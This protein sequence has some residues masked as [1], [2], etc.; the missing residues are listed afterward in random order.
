MLKKLQDNLKLSQE[1]LIRQSFRRYVETGDISGALNQALKYTDTR[2]VDNIKSSVKKLKRPDGHSFQAVY[3]LKRKY[4][5]QD[6]FLIY[7]INDGTADKRL[8]CFITLTEMDL[9]RLL[10]KLCIWMCC[11][12][13]QKDGRHI[14][15]LTTIYD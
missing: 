8:I 4:D 13:T 14:H 12:A 5:I 6:K 3:M 2:Y 7:D 9:I 1:S 10:R 11:I 15:C